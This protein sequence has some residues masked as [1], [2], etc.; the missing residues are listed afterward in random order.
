MSE[1]LN[2]RRPTRSE[3]WAALIDHTLLRPEATG[4]QIESLCS[5]AVGHGFHSVFVNPVHVRLARRTLDQLLADGRPP[6]RTVVGSVAGFPLGASRTE[7]KVDEVRRALDDGATEIDMVAHLG[8]LIDGDA[9]TVRADVLAVAEV[10]HAFPGGVLKVILEAAALPTE[11]VILGCRCAAEGEAD[12]V[13]TSTGSHPSGG[14]TIELVR[15]L[16]RHAAPMRVKASGGIRTAR[17]CAAMFDAGAARIGT[18]SGVAILSEF[19][20]GMRE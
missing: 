13:K 7:T 17:D 2:R 5:E 20:A 1:P 10:V 19:R 12:F 8:A 16:H 6:R 15:L 3:D 9:A 4:S 14:A 11:R 18:S